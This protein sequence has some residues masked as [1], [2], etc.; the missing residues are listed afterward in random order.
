MNVSGLS[1]NGLWAEESDYP[2]DDDQTVPIELRPTPK[3]ITD[4]N[5]HLDTRRD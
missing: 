2:R 5:I 1:N 3:E 4:D